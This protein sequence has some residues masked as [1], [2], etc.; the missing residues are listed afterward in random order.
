MNFSEIGK[1]RPRFEGIDQV[2][3]K[4][5]YVGDMYLPGMLYAKGLL[6]TEDHA[7]ILEI[8]T[9]P[10]KQL[11]GVRVVITGH[12]I[13][14]NITGPIVQDAYCLPIDKV[15]YRGEMIALVAADTEEIAEEAVSR[16]K[17]KYERLPAVF[18]P[19]DALQPDA[20]IVHD[21]FQGT[22][23]N[24]NLIL[25][26][27]HDV[28]RLVHGDVEQGFAESDLI[29]EHTFATT[30]ELGGA[31]EPYAVLAQPNGADGLTIW[32]PS[33]S[34]FANA[35]AI[36]KIL[37]LS[38]NKV[39]FIS[40]AVG[41]AF[42]QKA[43]YFEPVVAL[44]AL[45]TDRPVRYTFTSK[46]FFLHGSSRSPMYLTYKMG[47]K[48]DGKIMAI[49]RT[50]LTSAGAQASVGIL[51]THKGGFMGAGPY[52]SPNHYAECRVAYTNKVP[53]GAVR[54]FG[55]AQATFAMESMMD[56]IAEKLGMDP[57]EFRL[58][59]VLCDCNNCSPTGEN[60]KS[61][62]IRPCLE[63]VREMSGWQA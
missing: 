11:K 37:Q 58:K 14:V 28:S 17:V 9:S 38:T 31:I 24:G 63:K 18:D 21:E 60:M 40:P 5:T 51:I 56:I 47:V 46:E 42:G 29:V 35:G 55:M 45:K 25:M 23:C 61:I 3:G 10:A 34:P 32:A 48:S 15:R 8:D 27:G 6:S 13:P 4:S 22:L 57:L 44:A 30:P 39:R 41:G 16:I 20:P 2:T 12:D 52:Y 54:G 36:A 1:P 26:H 7:K 59:N 62:G 50:T 43:G 19:R 33:Q 53:G 49:Q